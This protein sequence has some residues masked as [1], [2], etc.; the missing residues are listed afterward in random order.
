MQDIWYKVG[1]TCLK[2]EEFNKDYTLLCMVL[3]YIEFS[4]NCT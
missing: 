2:W 4:K 3:Y 1:Q